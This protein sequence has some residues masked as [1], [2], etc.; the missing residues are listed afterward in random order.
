[1]RGPFAG[2]TLIESLASLGLLVQANGGGEVSL[3]MQIMVILFTHHR[4]LHALEIFCLSVRSNDQHLTPQP[5]RD[6]EM[7]SSIFRL[8]L[9]SGCPTGNLLLK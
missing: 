6:L 2:E 1:M 7:R 9:F 3:W 8:S 5:R 4:I